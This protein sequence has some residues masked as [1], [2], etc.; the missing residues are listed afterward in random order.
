MLTENGKQKSVEGV[1][2]KLL[3]F[4]ETRSLYVCYDLADGKMSG[5]APDGGVEEFEMACGVTYLVIGVGDL[6]TAYQPGISFVE[7]EADLTGCLWKIE[8]ADEGVWTTLCGELFVMIDGSPTENE[9]IFCPY[10]GRGIQEA[11]VSAVSIP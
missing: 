3:Q 7:I 4:E 2:L 1:V 6:P 5:V 11:A 9:M 10:C 8:N